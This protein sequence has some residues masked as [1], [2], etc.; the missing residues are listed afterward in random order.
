MNNIAQKLAL[1]YG[2]AVAH[3]QELEVYTDPDYQVL[4]VIK[5]EDPKANYRL[6]SENDL[7]CLSD[8]TRRTCILTQE[9]PFKN[10]RLV[11]YKDA[12][13]SINFKLLHGMAG[14]LVEEMA[15][16]CS[17]ADAFKET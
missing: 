12:S 14:R 9:S 15:L 7:Q 13:G 6:L 5:L 4:F 11:V 17:S 3:P 1:R 16:L 8:A 2:G 10:L